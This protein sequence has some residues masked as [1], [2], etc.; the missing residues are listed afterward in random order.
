MKSFQTRCWLSVSVTVVPLAT[1]PIYCM[2][3]IFFFQTW[4]TIRHAECPEQFFVSSRHYLPWFHSTE[5]AHSSTCFSV[6][7]T[8]CSPATLQLILCTAIRDLPV[9]TLASSVCLVNIAPP[10]IQYKIAGSP[11]SCPP[12][13]IHT[14]PA[15]LFLRRCWQQIDSSVSILKKQHFHG[16]WVSLCC[17]WF[18][19]WIS[20]SETKHRGPWLPIELNYMSCNLDTLRVCKVSV[21][22]IKCVSYFLPSPAVDSLPASGE[23]CQTTLFFPLCPTL[24]LVKM[25]PRIQSSHWLG[26][27]F[28]CS[29]KFL[30]FSLFS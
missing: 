29:F 25:P 16:I 22:H 27:S 5:I 10:R 3:S 8:H 12:P 24:W 28:Q 7:L 23:S 13:H 14:L 21:G 18:R 9:S 20:G 4:S 15:Q 2:M 26:W 30:S 19:P 11:S 1:L 6:P 17:S